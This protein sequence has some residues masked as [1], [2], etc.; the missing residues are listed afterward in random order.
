MHAVL[1]NVFVKIH[2]SDALRTIGGRGKIWSGGWGDPKVLQNLMSIHKRRSFERGSRYV[3]Y[4]FV[5]GDP[6]FQASTGAFR[7]DMY[8]RISYVYKHVGVN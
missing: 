1:D 5:L 6:R 8:S 2:S 4:V 3:E 7:V